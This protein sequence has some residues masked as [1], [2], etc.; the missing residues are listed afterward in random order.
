MPEGLV[1]SYYV[2][3]AQT[4][5]NLRALAYNEIDV[6]FDIKLRGQ[7]LRRQ[8][9]RDLRFTQEKCYLPSVFEIVSNLPQMNPQGED[10]M[11]AERIYPAR[12]PISSSGNTGLSS[13][14]ARVSRTIASSTRLDEKIVDTMGS[15]NGGSNEIEITYRAGG[16]VRTCT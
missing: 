12:Y 15:L 2:D 13:S 3:H 1:N 14:I 5:G 8:M 6:D 16:M 11:P 10:K 7:N 9:P 4:A